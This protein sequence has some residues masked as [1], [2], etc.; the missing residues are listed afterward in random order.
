MKP[1]PVPPVPYARSRR[2]LQW[3]LAGL[4][5]IPTASAGREILL[6]PQGVP[7]GSPAV[8]PTVDS[9]LRY[10]NVFKLA[11]GPVTWSQLG[12]VE[13][14]SSATFV[15]SSI[16]VGGFA[17]LWSWQQQGR[18]HPVTVAAVV[19]E[20]TAPPLLV[21]WQRRILARSTRIEH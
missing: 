1:R 21:A 12:R 2:R 10:A 8:V 4:A 9:A 6:G 11:V 14:S 13:Q 18:P 15:L 16:F 20:L 19:L 17:R 3:T 7:G 5:A